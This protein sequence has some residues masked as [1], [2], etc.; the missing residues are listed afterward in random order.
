VL[1]IS[2]ILGWLP[3]YEMKKKGGVA[4]GKSYMKTTKLVDTGI[5]AILRHPQYMAGILIVFAL[6]LI[7]QS[8]IITLLGIPNFLFFYLGLIEGDER[9]I[10][11][12]GDE[13]KKYM[14]RVPQTNFILGI[15]KY[16]GRRK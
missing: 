6:P 11:K 3:V 1:W 8:W 5:F 2:A 4:K 7:T 15:I 12:F 10:R 14:K 9:G 13:Y 16:L